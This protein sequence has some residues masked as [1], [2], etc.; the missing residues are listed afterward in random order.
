MCAECH[1]TGVR[2]TCD[3]AKD[4][5]CDDVGGEQRGLRDLSRAELAAH[6]LGTRSAELVAVRQARGPGQGISGEFRRAPW[7][8]LANRSSVRK[9]TALR[10]AGNAALEN[11]R[12]DRVWSFVSALFVGSRP[13]RPHRGGLSARG[14]VPKS[15]A[16]PGRRSGP[17]I[18]TRGTTRRFSCST[19]VRTSARPRISRQRTRRK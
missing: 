7:R 8:R 11:V 18:Q 17:P 2:K 12:A 19:W 1:S 5:F 16:R 13:R 6:R 4:R 9:R 3:A 10:G 15:I 14:R